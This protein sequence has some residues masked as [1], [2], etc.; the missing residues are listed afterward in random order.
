M[1]VVVGDHAL[2]LEYR[3]GNCNVT[4]PSTTNSQTEAVRSICTT[5]N[6]ARFSSGLGYSLPVR[7]FTLRAYKYAEV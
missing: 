2:D 3:R 6:Q 5:I 4:R 1:V 7:P